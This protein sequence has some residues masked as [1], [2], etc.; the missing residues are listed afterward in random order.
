MLVSWRG[1]LGRFVEYPEGTT[2]ILL[3]KGMKMMKMMK[4]MWWWRWSYKGGGPNLRHL[5]DILMLV[6]SWYWRGWLCRFV[7]YPEDTTWMEANLFDGDSSEHRWSIVDKVLLIFIVIVLFVFKSFIQTKIICSPSRIPFDVLD[8]TE[9][10][11]VYKNLLNQ[12]N[13]EQNRIEWVVCPLF[14]QGR[15][16]VAWQP[17]QSWG[18]FDNKKNPSL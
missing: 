16:W 18:N 10:E 3:I 9:A 11:T 1:W 7:E 15:K 2:W 17:M 14:F 8:S 6:S 5:H 4:V 13:A 12:L